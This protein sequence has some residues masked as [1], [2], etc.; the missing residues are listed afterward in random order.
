MKHGITNLIAVAALSCC[1]MALAAGDA[2][3]KSRPA[4]AKPATATVAA[5]PVAPTKMPEPAA[6][7]K[8][9]AAKEPMSGAAIKTQAVRPKDLDLRHCLDQG[10]DAAIAKCAGE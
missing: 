9:A 3:N 1:G 8:P 2:G 6:A 10:S 5:Q 7:K 4:E